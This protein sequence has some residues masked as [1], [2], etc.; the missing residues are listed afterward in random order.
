M[1]SNKRSSL[2]GVGLFLG[3]VA[4]ALG[5]LFFAPKSGKKLR[6]DVAKRAA[7]IKKQLKDSDVEKVVRDIFDEA[8]E[9]TIDAYNTAKD[10]LSEKIAEV[11]QSLQSIDK[12]KYVQLVG[13]VVE[14]VKESY[15]VNEEKI[16]K[17]KT[18]LI[19]EYTKLKTA[20]QKNNTAP[21]TKQ[22]TKVSK[23]KPAKKTS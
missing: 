11:S 2:F 20:V 21:I 13:G 15:D 9:K 19:N 22:K 5:G 16:A 23:K 10:L 17:L 1:N 12:E 18:Y 6:E 4:G 7:E 14:T 8:S 3:A